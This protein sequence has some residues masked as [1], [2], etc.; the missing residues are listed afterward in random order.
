MGEPF[1]SL[2]TAF[3]AILGGWV[4]PRV[5]AAV[6]SGACG[7]IWPECASRTKNSK[8]RPDLVIRSENRYLYVFSL[9]DRF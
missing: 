6:A 7:G 9:A 2:R 4:I 5:W 8:F 1:G 3:Y